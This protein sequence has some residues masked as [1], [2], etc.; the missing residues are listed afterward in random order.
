[1]QDENITKL[2]EALPF[3][4]FTKNTAYHQG[5]KQT[6]CEAMFGNVA[7][8]GLATRLLP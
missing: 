3:I 4:Q 6:W 1:M 5:I 8:R 7:K 2:S